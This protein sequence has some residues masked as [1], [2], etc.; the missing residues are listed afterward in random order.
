MFLNVGLK[1]I[2]FN[3]RE[4][5][6]ILNGR[7]CTFNDCARKKYEF[8]KASALIIVHH[9]PLR[10]AERKCDEKIFSHKKIKIPVV[11]G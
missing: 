6:N 7:L 11:W 5:Y 4:R 1:K 2:F 9:P 3:K 10:Q 8:A